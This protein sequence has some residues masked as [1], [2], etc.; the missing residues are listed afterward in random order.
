MNS[1]AS[2]EPTQWLAAGQG[3][4]VFQDCPESG[5]TL[6]YYGTVARV[7][8][9]SIRRNPSLPEHWV[10]SVYVRSFNRCVDVAASDLLAT[11]NWESP[12]LPHIPED[13]DPILELRFHGKVAQDNSVIE[14]AFRPPGREWW[15]FSFRKSAKRIP[16]MKSRTPF[17]RTRVMLR[18]S[19]I[20]LH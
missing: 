17:L 16:G 15:L 14:G 4:I 1:F 2:N 10:Y 11:G 12:D 8:T 7:R 6:G 20:A 19:A 13:A 18:Q 5:A 9:A 3:V